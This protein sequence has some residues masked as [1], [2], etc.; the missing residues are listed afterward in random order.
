M[1]KGVPAMD[2]ISQFDVAHTFDRVVVV[3]LA[4]RPERFARFC[5]SLTDWPF[6]TPQRFAAVDGEIVGVPAGWDKGPGAWGCMLSH[7]QILEHAIR[8]GMQSLFVLEDDACPVENFA[9]RAKEFLA[10]VP[11]DWDGLHFGAQHLL[12]PRPVGPGVVRCIASNR[13]HAFAVRGR[14]MPILL[15]FWQNTVNDH[16]DIVLSALM[17]HFNFYSPDPLLIG[18]DAGRSDINGRFEPLRFLSA[19]EKQSI[20][21]RNPR[22]RSDKLIVRVPA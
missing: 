6:K 22:Y 20:A 3:N 16:C 21:N 12:P 4:R 9:A 5:S 11:S 7:R 8:D 17:T 14:L 2:G 10:N 19:Q 13:T 1:R 18:Q 15:Q